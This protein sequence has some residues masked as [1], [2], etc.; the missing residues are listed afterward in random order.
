MWQWTDI[1][2]QENTW[3]GSRVLKDQNPALYNVARNKQSTMT[4]VMGI[5]PLNIS[6]K[7]AIVNRKLTE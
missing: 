3:L 6:F 2:F 7:R 4:E 1:R 5:T